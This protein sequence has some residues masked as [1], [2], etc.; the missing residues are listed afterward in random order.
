MHYP[1]DV[2]QLGPDS[3]GITWN[4]GHQSAYNVRD[5]RIECRC[6]LCVDEFTGFRTLDPDTIP[7]DIR[8]VEITLSGNYALVIVWSDGHRTGIYTFPHLREI[9]P[10]PECLGAA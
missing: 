10:C 2:K 4:D 1:T 6:A 3:L 5:L 7:D 9:C 8:P